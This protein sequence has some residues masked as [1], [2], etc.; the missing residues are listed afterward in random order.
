MKREHNIKAFKQGFVPMPDGALIRWRQFGERG[1]AVVLLHGN[2]EDYRCFSRQLLPLARRFQVVAVDSRGHGESSRGQGVTL[3]RM[4]D[5]LSRVLEALGI[6]KAH[7]VGFSD[8][9]NV[10]I[11][12]ALGHP[13]QL[14]RLVLIGGNLDPAGVKFFSQLP[15]EVGAWICRKLAPISAQARHNGEILELMTKEPSFTPEQLGAIQAPTLVLA[16]DRDMI[17]PEHT[18]L[19]AASI[20]HA[21]QYTLPNASHFLLRDQPELANRLLLRFLGA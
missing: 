5:D 15:C 17:R 19:I 14:D 21:R 9:A 20:P 8:G 6:A 4:S 2:G 10:A 13:G 18:A 7:L 3:G 11:H 16:G 12:F 1:P